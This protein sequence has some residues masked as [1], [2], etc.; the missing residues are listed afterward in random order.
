MFSMTSIL[1][2]QN[3]ES[4]LALNG[5]QQVCERCKHGS[6]ESAI[7]VPWKWEAAVQ[8][9]TVSRNTSHSTIKAGCP[10]GR[11]RVTRSHNKG[12]SQPAEEVRAGLGPRKF[13]VTFVYHVS[14][15]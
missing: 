2:L 7:H 3:G 4:F 12:R 13:G 6:P 5:V 14:D 11:H 10:F 1:W 15:C 8:V 9:F